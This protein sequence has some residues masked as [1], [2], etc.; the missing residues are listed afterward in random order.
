RSCGYN[1]SLAGFWHKL[2]DPSFENG[3]VQPL[4]QCPALAAWGTLLSDLVV[5]TVII[6]IVRQARTPEQRDRGFAL[7]V[8]GMLLVSPVTWDVW[9]PLL[10]IP[11]AVIARAAA[12]SPVILTVFLSIVL[13]I[14]IPQESLTTLFGHPCGLASPVYMLAAP[15]VK[16]YALLGVLALLI[17]TERNRI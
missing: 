4:W 15:S 3:R 12:H 1:I 6:N 8:T 9:L 13:A 2:F 5:T 16:F 17:R 10:I 7:V 11:L 14:G